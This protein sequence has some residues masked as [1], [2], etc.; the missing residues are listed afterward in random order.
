MIT[1]SARG[2][3]IEA[4]ILLPGSKSISNRFLLLDQICGFHHSF[5]NLSDSEDTQLLQKALEQ[6]NNTPGGVIDVHHAGT[7]MR[8]LTAYLSTREGEWTLTGS[9]RMKQRP[10]GGL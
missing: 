7:D 3:K 9:S 8:F 6:I 5:D 2:K 4:D 1:L 10:I